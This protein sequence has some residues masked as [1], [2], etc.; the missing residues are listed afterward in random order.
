MAHMLQDKFQPQ[1]PYTDPLVHNI[2]AH[3]RQD[4]QEYDSLHQLHKLSCT[5]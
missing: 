5:L 2:Q 3:E 1:F 4:Y